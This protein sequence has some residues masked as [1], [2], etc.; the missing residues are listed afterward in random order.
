MIALLHV[1]GEYGLDGLFDLFRDGRPRFDDPG[2]V[3]REYLTGVQVWFMVRNCS[4]T[5]PHFFYFVEPIGIITVTS[6]RSVLFKLAAGVRFPVG[7]NFLKARN[8]LSLRG[9]LLLSIEISHQT[10]RID[11]LG[12]PFVN[13]L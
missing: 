13:S 3:G 9:L 12:W 11:I 10:N 1:G 2:Q 5:C 8:S 4:Q 6:T 7:A